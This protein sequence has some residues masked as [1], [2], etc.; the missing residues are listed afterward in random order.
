MDTA[1]KWLHVGLKQMFYIVSILSWTELPM[2]K[3]LAAMSRRAPSWVL[4]VVPVRTSL[5]WWLVADQVQC[6]HYWVRCVLIIDRKPHF[7]Q[8]RACSMHIVTLVPHPYMLME[9]VRVITSNTGGQEWSASW[10]AP[11]WRAKLNS[12]I[13]REVSQEEA[14]FSWARSMDCSREW[15]RRPF[16]CLPIACSSLA[17][18][19]SAFASSWCAT[20]NFTGVLKILL[21]DCFLQSLC[22]LKL[23]EERNSVSVACVGLT[24]AKAIPS[25][26]WLVELGSEILFCV[27]GLV[28]VYFVGGWGQCRCE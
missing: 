16:R 5:S 14:P 6:K 2:Q 23:V 17:L 15:E 8:D 21:N 28:L 3:P 20:I 12:L 18:C 19:T 24:R 25:I 4:G 1:S 7:G 11:L 13:G 27:N 10:N 9:Y 26:V 22:N